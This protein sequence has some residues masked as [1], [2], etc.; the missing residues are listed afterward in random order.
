MDGVSGVTSQLGELG[1]GQGRL[2]RWEE[3]TLREDGRVPL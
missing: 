1:G 2:L 3:H